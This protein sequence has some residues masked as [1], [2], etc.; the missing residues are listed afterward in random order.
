MHARNV[1]APERPEPGVGGSVLVVDDDP[2][3]QL[4][5]EA[6]LESAGYV[7][8]CVGSVR[9][10]REAIAVAHFPIVIVDRMLADGDG[11]TLCTELR[12]RSHPGRVF[13]L[14]LSG[15]DSPLEVG[16]GLRAGADVYLNKRTSDAEL[17]AYLEAASSVARFAA[18]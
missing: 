3:I 18:K 5:L 8:T 11:I 17:L 14:V 13:V 15:H 1:N 10:A 9:Q 6:L 12:T 4:K 2:L 7:V 16:L